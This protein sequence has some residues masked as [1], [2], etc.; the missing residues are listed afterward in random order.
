MA[1]MRHEHPAL[2]NDWSL[3][4]FPRLM[5]SQ[6]ENWPALTGLGYPDLNVLD[7][8]DD[9]EGMRIEEY[10]DDNF[11][12]IKAEVPGVDPDN[13]IEIMLLN[14][15]LD[16]HVERREEHET[17]DENGYYRSEFSYGEF[18]R[19]VAVPVGT[20]SQDVQA[21]Y[22]DGILEIRVPVQGEKVSER[23]PVARE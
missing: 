13:D 22:R 18:G 1:A 21:S 10:R 5:G 9:V 23:V 16:I 7:D 17:T 20:T 12:V 19:R 3:R 14:G 15:N 4:G 6:F 8:I 2:K 11:L